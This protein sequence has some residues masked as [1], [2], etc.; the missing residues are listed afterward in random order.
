LSFTAV[1][2]I[3][4][5]AQTASLKNTGNAPLTIT[6]ITITG[7]NPGDF[8]QTNTCGSS[9]DAGA[10]CAISVTFTPA[11]AATF[12]ASLSIADNATGSPHTVSL[13][14]SGTAAPSFTVSSS[15]AA[16][17]IPTGGSAQYSVTVT[18]HNGTFPNSVALTAS[19]LPIGATATFSPAS[20]SP[21][22]GSATSQLTINT[23]S[24]A[25]SVEDHNT[26]WKFAASALPLFGFLFAIKRFRQRWITMGIF[27]LVS[28]GA[29]TAISGCG[30]GFSLPG[31]TAKT[32]SI[33]VTGTSG[34]EQQSTTV[35]LIVK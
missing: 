21:G 29:A 35:E 28:L 34:A 32:Y 3:T 22:S 7:A 1:A 5:A 2:G 26:S 11:S 25:A 12:T 9:L 23:A 18:A 19:G 6:G 17:T 16:Q 27:I 31:S 14:G 30:G 15:T 8:A 24:T 33:T 13:Q 10:S 4:T 20:V